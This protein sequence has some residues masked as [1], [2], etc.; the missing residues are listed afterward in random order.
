LPLSSFSASVTLSW[1]KVPS[2][3]YSLDGNSWMIPYKYNVYYGVSSGNYTNMVSVQVPQTNITIVNLVGGVKYYFAATCM[4]TNGLESPYSNEAFYLVPTG[5]GENHPPTLNSI[6]DVSMA[7]NSAITINLTGISSGDSQEQ[8]LTISAVSSKLQVVPN[9]LV[10]Y[11]NPN[12]TGSL[13]LSPVLNKFGG[14]KITVT[15]ND[16]Q[17]VSNTFSRAFYVTVNTT[18]YR[19]NKIVR[20]TALVS[21][22]LLNWS[23]TSLLLPINLTNPVGSQFLRLNIAETEELVPN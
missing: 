15:V 12:S 2:F 3:C 23:E 11:T 5:G 10:L 19:T 17:P 13:R 6:P 22:N 7:E 9:P 14:A 20:A 1:E 16:H 8:P 4:E 21:T 18:R